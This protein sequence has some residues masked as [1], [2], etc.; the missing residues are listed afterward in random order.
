M[1]EISGN[2]FYDCKKLTSIK[3]ASGNKYFSSQY[4]VLFDKNK[5]TLIAYPGG[6]KG[7]AYTVPAS[8]KV[9]GEESDD[10]LNYGAKKI[11]WMK[12]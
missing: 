4:G 8:V 2:T 9:I 11:T 10:L 6:K 3:V 1:K 5:N 7:K 12:Y